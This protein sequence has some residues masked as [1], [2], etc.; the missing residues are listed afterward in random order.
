MIGGR[1]ID[2][3]RRSRVSR[4]GDGL[5]GGRRLFRL[6]FLIFALVVGASWLMIVLSISQTLGDDVVVPS[7]LHQQVQSRKD[8]IL[9]ILKMAKVTVVG[10]DYEALP[11]WEQVRQVIGDK[12]RILGLETCRA[13]R[14]TVPLKRRQVAPAGMFSTG[15]NL[16][17]HLL[18]ANCLVSGRPQK[19][20][21]ASKWGKAPQ[22]S[23]SP[24]QSCHTIHPEQFYCFPGSNGTQS[25]DVASINVPGSVLST[26][27]PW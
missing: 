16:L 21:V 1:I 15:T 14:E 24:Y 19:G 20:F 4:S 9:D 11:S 2:K 10:A 12:P 26:L 3:T 23:F 13:Y 25:M 18:Q 22:S 27:V 6:V 17:Q 7:A 5:K 8:P